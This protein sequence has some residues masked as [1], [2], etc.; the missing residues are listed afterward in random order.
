LYVNRCGSL[1]S[2]TF[3]QKMFTAAT[4]HKQL[5]DRLRSLLGVMMME[6]DC[7]FGQPQTV[8]LHDKTTGDTPANE[9]KAGSKRSCGDTVDVGTVKR[10]KTS[11][12]CTND[13]MPMFYY[14]L[15]RRK[16]KGVDLPK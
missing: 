15:H 10:L 14:N 12:E 9:M 3:L 4:K 16:M 11:G 7:G 6:A 2:P 5:S 8:D 1:Y 13:T